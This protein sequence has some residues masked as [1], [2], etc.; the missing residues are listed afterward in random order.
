MHIAIFWRSNFPHGLALANRFIALAKGLIEVGESVV[1]VCVAPAS[2]EQAPA[3]LSL[4]GTLQGIE[5]MY[6]TADL[7]RA[8]SRLRHRLQKLRG[9]ARGIKELRKRRRD[10]ELDVIFFAGIPSWQMATL[11]LFG[12]LSGIR[13]VHERNEYP[14]LEAEGRRLRMVERCFYFRVL[15]RFCSGVEVLSTQLERLFRPQIGRKARL[16]VVPA[17]VDASRFE[18]GS[19]VES[20]PL[21]GPYV[22]WCGG[23]WGRKDGVH[24]LI[25]A[26][27][28]VAGAHPEVS[29][30]LMCPYDNSVDYTR[31]REKIRE[32]ACSERIVT[33]GRVSQAQMPHYLR[34]AAVLALARP[35]SVQ[36]E[37]GFPTKLPEYLITGRPVLATRVGDIP[38]YLTDGMN[39]Y[40]VDPDDVAAFAEKLDYI[41]EHPEEAEEVGQRGRALTMREFSNVLQAGRLASFFREL[42]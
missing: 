13:V 24:Q 26:F 10:D 19:S 36:A 11:L 23:S 40:L 37:Y 29:L 38:R 8:E 9:F 33:T 34:G 16:L 2:R 30:V 17:V 25:D 15:V 3:D 22:A 1:V 7:F 4:H 31:A 21:E 41:L 39:A 42:T 5:Y 18:L 14:F 27:G 6:T 20:P 32:T 28:R 12:R 35:T